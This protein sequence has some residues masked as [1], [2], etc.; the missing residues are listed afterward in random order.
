M[1]AVAAEVL[2]AEDFT[3]RVELPPPPKLEVEDDITEVEDTAVEDDTLLLL[4]LPSETPDDDEG[5]GDA[6]ENEDVDVEVVCLASSVCCLLTIFAMAEFAAPAVALTG[7]GG[8]GRRGRL[9]KEL[10]VFEE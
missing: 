3:S 5:D 2:E 1:A 9:P 4:W 10:I 6:E 8:A 7:T